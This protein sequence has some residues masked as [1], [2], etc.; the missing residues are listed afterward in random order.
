MKKRLIFAL[1]L[2][3]FVVFGQSKTE[4]KLI[5]LEKKRFEAMISRDVSALREMLADDLR[6]THSN[7]KFE[8]KAEFL[9]E[10][11][12]GTLRYQRMEPTEI[13]CRIFKKTAVITGL[14]FVSVKQSER[15]VESQLRYTDVWQKRNGR[16]QLVAWQS[17]RVP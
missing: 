7:A 15:V 10:I 3:P 14:V 8:S 9:T 5:E 17:V 6:Y 11:T 16:W 12:D 4:K 2:L 1:F 13:D